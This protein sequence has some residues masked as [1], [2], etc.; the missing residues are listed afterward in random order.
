M[1]VQCRYT[2][3]SVEK[4]QKKIQSEKMLVYI[5]KMKGSKLSFSNSFHSNKQLCENVKQNG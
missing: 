1:T 4:D 3:L 5:N 2:I